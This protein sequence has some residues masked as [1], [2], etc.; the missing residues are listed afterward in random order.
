MRLK[1]DQLL[2]EDLLSLHFIWLLLEFVNLG[3]NIQTHQILCQSLRNTKEN[4]SVPISAGA[5][6]PA[7]LKPYRCLY[8]GD[9]P[10][11][12]QSKHTPKTLAPPSSCGR[13][14]KPEGQASQSI[15][16]VILPEGFKSKQLSL[17]QVRKYSC[18]I[19]HHLG[20]GVG[21]NAFI[22]SL[23]FPIADMNQ[24]LNPDKSHRLLLPSLPG[25]RIRISG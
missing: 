19:H 15:S 5:E 13:G 11:P 25:R 17:K 9:H 1:H 6:D 21:G 7:L 3:K 2:Y 16:G 10:I 8:S 14:F 4:K 18:L 24:K 23:I 20:G 22:V 12:H